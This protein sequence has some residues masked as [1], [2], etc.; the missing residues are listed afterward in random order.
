MKKVKG[1]LWES[2]VEEKG[3]DGGG[4]MRRVSCLLL[5]K[6]KAKFNEENL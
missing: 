3:V 4:V 6:F 1:R 5:S 2:Y